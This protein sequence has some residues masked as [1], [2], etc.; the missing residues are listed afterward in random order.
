MST[1]FNQKSQNQSSGT[2]TYRQYKKYT[3]VA[4]EVIKP[5]PT[6]NKSVL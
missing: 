5:I 4:N 2:T 3:V 6:I 1:D